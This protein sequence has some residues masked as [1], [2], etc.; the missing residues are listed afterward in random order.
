MK[1]ASLVRLCLP[2]PPTPTS[3]AFP[4]GDSRI[5]LM[6]QLRRSKQKPI[7][8][9][10]VHSEGH[11]G[12]DGCRGSWSL[13]WRYNWTLGN[14]HSLSSKL[15][16]TFLPKCT[17]IVIV[18]PK[19]RGPSEPGRIREKS[20]AAWQSWQGEWWGWRGTLGDF[21]LLPHWIY[22]YP[23]SLFLTY[24]WLWIKEGPWKWRKVEN[25]LLGKQSEKSRDAKGKARSICLRKKGNKVKA[26][27]RKQGVQA[28]S[29]PSHSSQMLMFKQW[30]FA[31]AECQSSRCSLRG[32]LDSSPLIC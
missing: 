10:T 21:L 11:E 22:L 27:G 31:D 17:A 25:M 3:R 19:A 7:T 6:W 15:G 16:V 23:N 9:A 28:K 12:H 18:L 30:I 4:R 32:V 26:T 24:L 5:R 14:F 13:S 2:L 1:A 29:L 8:E 20:R